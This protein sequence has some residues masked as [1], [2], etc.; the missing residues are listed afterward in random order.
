MY[1][2]S[3]TKSQRLRAFGSKGGNISNLYKQLSDRHSDLY[4]SFKMREFH[5]LFYIEM[6]SI[7]SNVMVIV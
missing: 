5:L 2:L 7:S 3:T 4:K 6:L 1:K